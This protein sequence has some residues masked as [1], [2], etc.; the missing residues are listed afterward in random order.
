MSQADQATARPARPADGGAA[1]VALARRWADEAARIPPDRSAAR[2][3]ALLAD[4][5][6]LRFAVRFIDGV[7]R[8]ED[9]AT[10]ARAFAALAREAPAFLPVPLRA[11]ARAGAIAAPHAPRLA[12]PVIRRV[13]RGMVGHLVVDASDHRLGAAL[14]RLRGRGY[15]LNLNLLGEA[16]L[17]AREADRRLAGIARLVA[18]PDV[19]HVSV[20]V[21]AAVAP[22]SPWAFDEEVAH[23]TRRLL[24]LYLQ[25]AATRPAPTF[26]TLDMEEY[27]DLDLT[28]AVFTRLLDDP[29]LRSLSAGL[30]LQA[31]LPDSLGALERIEAWAAERRLSGGA[32]VKVRLVKGANL[33]M[34]RVEAQLRGWPQATWPTKTQTDTHYLRLLD[35]ALRPERVDAVRVGVAGHNLFD[36]AHAWLLAGE[37]GVRG[38]VDIEMLLGMAAGQAEAVRRDVGRLLLYTPVVHPGEFDV[39]IAYLVRRL[40]EGAAPQNFLPASGRLTDPAVFARERDRYLASLAGLDAAP[41]T[42]PATF[43]TQDRRVSTGPAIAVRAFA[44]APDTDPATAAG[45]GWARTILARAASSTLGADAVA[46]HTVDDEAA[47]RALLAGAAQAGAEWGARPAAERAGV[48]RAAADALERRR[49]ELIEVMAAEAGKTFA[50]ADPEVSEAV[51]FARHY[52]DCAERLERYPGARFVPVPLAV[53]APPWNFPVAIPAG[54]TLAALAAG[55]AVVLTPAPQTPRCGEVLAAALWEAGVPPD[56]LRV[57]HIDEATLGPV[58]VTDPHVRRF[59]LTGAYDTAVL[60]R[61]QRP[62]LPLLAETSG[63]NAIVVTASADMDLAVRDVVHSAF[64]HAGQKCSAASLVILVGAAARS[65]RF[66]S[67]LVDA[68]TS[69][70]AG[71]PWDPAT[72]MGPLIEPAGGKLLRALTVLDPGERWL[73]RPR[74]LDD[75]GRLWTPGVKEGVRAGSTAHRVEFF[76]PVLSVMHA[77]TLDEAI[78]LQNAIDYGL[79]AG[80]HTLDA[81]EAARWLDAV[82]AGNLYVNRGIT[83]AIVRRQPFGGWKRSSVGPGCKAGGPDYLT[84]LGDWLPEPASRPTAPGGHPDLTG[85]PAAQD[86]AGLEAERNLLRYRPVPVHV[87]LAEGEPQADLRRVLDVARRA[88]APVTVST[89]AVESDAAWRAWAARH[90]PP[91]IRLLGGDPAALARALGGDPSVAVYA[92]PVTGSDRLEALPFLREQA[93]SVTAHRF[94]TPDA[95]AD[96]LRG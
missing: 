49:G 51:D 72:R 3:A 11:A 15:E 38:G 17:G 86:A 29:R 54:G 85:F 44:N 9:D 92:Q 56:V 81:G 63:K 33:P 20:K 61:S 64:S 43:R 82:E 32:P 47:L 96:V 19:D 74:R 10:A 7:I 55:S 31:Y 83:G 60:L 91:R 27:R 53:V 70:Q 52:A 90:R 77:G 18:R 24:P 62:G 58:L 14:A 78:A 8:P 66:R 4:P 59:I 6:G 50:E 5:S 69:L 46:R 95:L 67:Q 80:L 71:W 13:L 12:V 48:L 28:V 30:A 73:V 35:A 89:A 34:E 75:A 1:A 22:Q 39:A 23:V 41:G 84:A 65:R 40:D 21:S 45:R 37:R 93:V 94:G 79:T 68:V 87:R 88:G 76:G 57:A 25:A 42:V 36:V 26:L 2:L 16:V